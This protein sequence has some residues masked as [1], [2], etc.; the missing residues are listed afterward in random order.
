MFRFISLSAIAA[1]FLVVGSVGAEPVMAGGYHKKHY[2][3]HHA[4]H[5]RHHHYRV[6]YVYALGRAIGAYLPYKRHYYRHGHSYRHGHAHRYRSH[7][8]YAPRRGP[9][10]IVPTRRVISVA[11]IAIS[12][13]VAVRVT[14]PVIVP[15]VG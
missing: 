11:A 9:I 2:H 13:S 6:P 14:M 10:R 8:Y 7:R 5:G 1:A 4:R 3:G 12:V 15:F